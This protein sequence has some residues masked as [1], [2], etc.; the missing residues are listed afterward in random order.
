MSMSRNRITLSAAFVG[1]FLLGAAA[2][3]IATVR[4]IVQPMTDLG[5]LANGCVAGNEAYVRYRYG[6]YSVAKAALLEN[7]NRL[8]NTDRALPGK[9]LDQFDLGLTYGRL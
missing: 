3:S 7:A 8:K 9:G 4:R 5:N 6:S 1:V 2:G